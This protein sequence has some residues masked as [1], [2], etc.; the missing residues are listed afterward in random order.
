MRPAVFLDRDGTLNVEVVYLRSPDQVRLIDG[1]PQALNALRDAG[2]AL[3]VITNQS[4][5]ARGYFDAAT[6]DAIHA[7]LT[8]ALAVQGARVDGI[9][10]CPH[11]PDDNCECRK[12]RSRLFQRA[13]REHDIDLSRSLMI[14]D[15]DTDLLAARNLGMPSILVRTGYGIEQLPSVAAWS[16]YQPA[17]IADDLG[18]AARWLLDREG[19]AAA[20][21]R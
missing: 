14:G 20:P 2:Y 16:D 12:P 7:R 3:I 19:S 17:Y 15:K 18:D 4:G 9:Y 10:V 11:H 6:L 13:A 8:G 5:L 1:V 21:F